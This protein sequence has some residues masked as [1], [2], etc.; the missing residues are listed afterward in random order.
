MR[1]DYDHD[2]VEAK[3]IIDDLLDNIDNLSLY[4]RGLIIKYVKHQEKE[5]QEQNEKIEEYR[6]WFKQLDKFLP[7]K[8]PKIY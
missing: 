4:N 8:N 3:K 6:N 7:N 5:I 2:L 1:Y